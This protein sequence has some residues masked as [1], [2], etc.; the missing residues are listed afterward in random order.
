MFLKCFATNGASRSVSARSSTFEI[1]Q[2]KTSKPFSK[3]ASS[4]FCRKNQFPIESK[5]NFFSLARSFAPLATRPFALQ[6]SSGFSK[7]LNYPS[8]GA[9]FPSSKFPL[10][11]GPRRNFSTT[12]AKWRESGGQKEDGPEVDSRQDE[13]GDKIKKHKFG[14]HV[15]GEGM[16]IKNADMAIQFTCTRCDTRSTKGF[17]RASYERGVVIVQCPGCKNLHLIADNFGWFSSNSS[18]K[19]LTIEKI[20]RDK[21]VQVKKIVAPQSFVMA[22]SKGGGSSGGNQ[23]AFDLSGDFDI[24]PEDVLGKESDN[25]S[26]N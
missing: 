22:A 26:K 7:S 21:G 8:S 10:V 14:I 12:A 1:S 9:P 17:T 2:Y 15:G 13:S 3:L 5:L 23:A 24:S 4:N 19:S 11:S 20:M 25:G 6:S 16:G 18:D